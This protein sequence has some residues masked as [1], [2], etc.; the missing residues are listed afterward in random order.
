MHEIL[1]PFATPNVSSLLTLPSQKSIMITDS[2]IN[3]QRMEKIIENV[4][5]SQPEKD[6]ITF[7]Y[8]TKRFNAKVIASIFENQWDVASFP[9]C[10]CV[11]I[12]EL[13]G[14]GERRIR[15]RLRG[16]I[17]GRIRGWRRARK[18]PR[19]HHSEMAKA[20]SALRACGFC[21]G[22][23][24]ARRDS[25]TIGGGRRCERERRTLLYAGKASNRWKRCSQ[26]ASCGAWLII[27]LDKL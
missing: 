11:L 10:R 25:T 24:R 17:R 1:N 9:V 6:I 8:E 13:V 18:L 22:C 12:V 21:K 20:V 27:L 19:R 26:A 15:G 3:L 5:Q 2:L 23:G 16:R 4:D 14:L 7:W